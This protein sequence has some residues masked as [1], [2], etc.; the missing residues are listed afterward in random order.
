MGSGNVGATNVWRIC[1]AKV[2]A[3]VFAL[4]IAKGLI[5]PLVGAALGM[6]SYWQIAFAMLAILG[7]IYSF[8][9]GFK[10]GKGVATGLGAFFGVAP[11]VAAI[12]FVIW[13]ALY[14]CFQYVSIS[15]L[16]AIVGLTA[17]MPVFYPGDPYRLAFGIV[18]TLLGIY[19][20]RSNIR[21]LLKGEEPKTYLFGKKKSK[22]ESG[23]NTPTTPVS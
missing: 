18:C 15:S 14:L 23:A 3:T 17:L 9:L 21:R 4:D 10:G 20:H 8:W 22:P 5:P 12:D 13:I 1:G 19:T 2:G 16:A 7:H 11:K 6:P